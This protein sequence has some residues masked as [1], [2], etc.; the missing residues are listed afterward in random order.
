MQKVACLAFRFGLEAAL[1]AEQGME[2][3]HDILDIHSGFGA[4][5]HDYDPEA[6]LLAH[7]T[8]SDFILHSQVRWA[9][10]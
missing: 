8:N 5:Y 10:R 6:L 4:F 9:A 3:N 2:G 1:L 7:S